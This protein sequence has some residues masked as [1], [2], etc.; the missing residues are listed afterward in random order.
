[1]PMME[2]EP[3]HDTKDWKTRFVIYYYTNESSV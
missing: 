2:I 3:A 1:M